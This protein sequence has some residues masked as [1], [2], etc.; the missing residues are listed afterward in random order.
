MEPRMNYFKANPKAF[1]KMMDM[2]TFAKAGGIDHT[3]YELI[4]MRASQIN[5]CAFCMDMHAKELQKA[6]E[7][8]DRIVLLPAWREVPI[9]SEQE[10]AVLELTEHVTLIADSGVPEHVYNQVRNYFD[11]KQYVQ[12][13]MAINTINCWNRLAIS[14]GMFP[15]CLD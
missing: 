4:K 8:T 5:N 14:T 13:I 15:G 10:K 7:S 1:E 6:G 12:L 3:L 2:E 9:Y 11:E